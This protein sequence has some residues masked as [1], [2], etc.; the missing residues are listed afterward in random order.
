MHVRRGPAAKLSE[1]ASVAG[2][3]SNRLPPCNPLR[4][5]ARWC[6]IYSWFVVRVVV[7]RC[8]FL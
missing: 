3:A 7:R 6:Q 4:T 8:V 5:V 1:E 2:T